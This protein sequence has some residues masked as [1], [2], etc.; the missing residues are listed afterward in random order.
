MTDSA[1]AGTEHADMAADSTRIGNRIEHAPIRQSQGWG[2]KVDAIGRRMVWMVDREPTAVRL[3]SSP[4]IAHF[5]G[6]RHA[7]QREMRQG[8]IAAWPIAARARSCVNGNS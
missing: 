7:A 5:I 8:R 3:C 2:C 6:K 4:L 1:P